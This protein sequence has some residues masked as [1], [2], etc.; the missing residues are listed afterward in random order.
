MKRSGIDLNGDVG[1]GG[2]QEEGLTPFLTSVNI[3][4]GGHAGDETS[5]L[6]AVRSAGRVGAAI[7]AHPSFPDRDH[8]GRREMD[9]SSTQ[10]KHWLTEQILVLRSIVERSGA[11]LRHVKPHGA[12]YNQAARDRALAEV[13]AETV[14]GIDSTLLL[15][16]L[17]G[18]ELEVAG[19]RA[20]LRVIAEGFVDRA[21][22]GDGRLAPRSQPGAVMEDEGLAIEQALRLA[23]GQPI[24]ALSGGTVCPQVE[25]LCIHGD[26]PNAVVFARRLRERLASE[27]IAVRP[28]P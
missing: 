13:V 23:R 2:L 20:G 19:R 6:R 15:V 9:A 4:C 22:L 16:A 21:Y 12:L 28:P 10:V 7:G 11:R 26:G 27:G 25:T 24:A 5:M 3:A 1:E 17:A 8:F 18:S 14:A